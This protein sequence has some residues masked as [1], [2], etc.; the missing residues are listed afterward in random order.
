MDKSDDFNLPPLGIGAFSSSDSDNVAQMFLVVGV[1]ALVIPCFS[2]N[3][4]PGNACGG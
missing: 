1:M 4:C 2:R 3:G